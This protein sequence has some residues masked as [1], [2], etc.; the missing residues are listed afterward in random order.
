MNENTFQRIA[1]SSGIAVGLLATSS[2]PLYFLYSGAPPA[3]N[4]LTRILLNILAGAATLIFLA[5]LRQLIRNAGSDLEWLAS[6]AF[7]AGLAYVTITLVA[8]S[9]EAGVVLEHSGG[10]VDPTIH[11]P[12]AHANMLMHGS[13]SRLLT[14]ILLTAVG[15][16]ITRGGFLPSWTGRSAYMIAAANLVFVPSLF[17]GTDA[18]QFY[19]AVGW[20]NSALTAALIG[21]WALAVGIVMVKRNVPSQPRQG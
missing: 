14:A 15:Y 18:S 20:G 9:I 17:F 12:L 13:I 2:V 7:G 10:G 8:A 11:G 19:S 5:G 4:V 3:G 1:G 21:Y 6:L 16:A